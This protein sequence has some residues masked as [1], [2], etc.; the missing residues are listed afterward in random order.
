M[1]PSGEKGLR[2]EYL[3]AWWLLW[4]SSGGGGVL[5]GVATFWPFLLLGWLLKTLLADDLREKFCFT[6]LDLALERSNEKS[7]ASL[8]SSS[9]LAV[10]Y[11]SALLLALVKLKY[12]LRTLNNVF[13]ILEIRNA[14]YK[15]W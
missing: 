4:Q 11:E 12:G 9:S 1:E 8:A 7:G 3:L 5:K 13:G 15:T 6:G 10:S 14:S 2:V